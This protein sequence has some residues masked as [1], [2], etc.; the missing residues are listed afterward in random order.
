MSA[1]TLGFVS[2]NIQWGRGVDGKV[3]LERIV[4]CLLQGDPD[5]LMLQEVADGFADLPGHDGSDQ[6]AALA[7]LLPGY[8]CVDAPGTDIAGDGGRRRR[9]GNLLATRL[10]VLQAWRHLLPW[11]ADPA[12]PAGKKPA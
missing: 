8:A 7:R 11:P 10:P 9:F 6:F 2:W 3:D 12:K 5:V 4:S 1:R